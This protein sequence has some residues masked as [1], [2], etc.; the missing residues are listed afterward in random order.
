MRH[1]LLTMFV[2]TGIIKFGYWYHITWLVLASSWHL[3]NQLTLFDVHRCLGSKQPKIDGDHT[4]EPLAE[5]TGRMPGTL[6]WTNRKWDLRTRHFD[7]LMQHGDVSEILKASSRHTHT[8]VKGWWIRI[9]QRFW[10]HH[11]D[12]HTH[13]HIQQLGQVADLSSGI[14]SG[15]WLFYKEKL[16]GMGST[17]PEVTTWLCPSPR[18]FV[19]CRT[20]ISIRKSHWDHWEMVGAKTAGCDD[21]W[22]SRWFIADSLSSWLQ[23]HGESPSFFEV[24]LGGMWTIAWW[25]GFGLLGTEM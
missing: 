17:S 24:C 14:C 7:A 12:T 13:S 8:H 9:L 22:W 11:P 18:S 1:R 6:H 5:I 19:A 15:P 25:P 16:D 2:S 10:K 23:N 20:T 21:L 3:E 4:F